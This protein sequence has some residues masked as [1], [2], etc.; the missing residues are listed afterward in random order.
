[1]TNCQRGNG[2]AVTERFDMIANDGE[3][4]TA[5][6]ALGRGSKAS[7]SFGSLSSKPTHAWFS[8]TRGT[9]FDPEINDGF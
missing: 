6:Y 7:I 8:S 4:G 3:V 5:L 9:H 1:M 2:R